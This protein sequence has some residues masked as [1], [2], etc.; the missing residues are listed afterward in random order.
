VRAALGEGPWRLTRRL[1]SDVR[2]LLVSALALGLLLGLAWGGALRGAW[3]GVVASVGWSGAVASL[4]PALALLMGLAALAYVWTGLSMARER[5]LARALVSGERVTAAPGEAF[6]RRMLTAVQ[7]GVAGA[8]TLGAL[9]LSMGVRA[10]ASASAGEVRTVAAAVTAPGAPGNAWKDLLRRLATIPGLEAESLSTPGALVGLGIRDYATAQCGHCYRGGLPLPFW[11]A[12]ADHHAVGPDFFRLAGMT[13]G[14]G[15]GFTEADG[16]D[17]P[18]VAVVN[19]TFANTAFEK[20]EPLGHKVRLGIELDAWYEVVGIVEDE[21]VL[22]VGG[23][24]LARAAV[25]VSALQDPPGSGSLLLEGS[26]DG[27]TRAL[28]VATSLGFAPS[29]PRSVAQVRR[30][31]QASTRWLGR[32]GLVLTIL[33]LALAV[34][35][36]H[37]T[38]LQVARRRVR[39]LAVR[40]ALGATDLRIVRHVL[41]GAAGTALGGCAVAVFFGSLLVALLRKVEGSVPSLGPGTYLGVVAL[42]VLAGLVASVRAAREAVA[43]EPGL[44]VE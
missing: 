40:R 29:A 22:G 26:D 12:L 42:L 41:A 30:E 24:D 33:T 11:G 13:V 37:T 25:Y 19:R 15:R 16:P 14:A 20:G 4:A 36:A 3:P 9:A 8:V 18:R 38:A 7:M 31:A 27:V 17:A 44:V 32:L 28:D 39:E 1:L 23:D 35:G 10:P 34:H 5:S 43:V 21:P 2:R 6:Q